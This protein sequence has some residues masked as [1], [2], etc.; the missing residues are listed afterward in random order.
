MPR[1]PALVLTGHDLCTG[2]TP[3]S[4][5]PTNTVISVDDLA[6]ILRTFQAQGYRFVRLADFLQHRRQGGVALLTFDDAY[7]ALDELGL[8]LL[9]RLGVPA[10]VFA[11]TGSL[12]GG[13]DP[14][15]HFIDELRDKWP[16]LSAE[17]RWSIGDHS[18]TRAILAHSGHASL[19]ELLPLE[20]VH[21]AF[22][23]A[24]GPT[25]LAD[26]STFLTGKPGLARRTM[27]VDDV[28][29][30]QASDLIEIGAH[31]VTHRAFI[32]M[33][34]ADVEREIAQ[35]TE[36]IAELSGRPAGSIAFAYPYGFV[37]AHAAA[38]VSRRCAAGFTCY[39]RPLS[40]LDRAAMLPRINLDRRT[41]KIARSR[42]PT[43]SSL[44][45]ETRLYARTPAGQRI[46]R[47]IRA[48]FRA[49]RAG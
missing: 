2:Q 5:S 41:L 36:A 19:G 31:S 32:E 34:D 20:S 47:P 27:T 30:L 13:G 22:A 24:L 45:E 48:L 7:R 8:P 37:T 25:A 12:L 6:A 1:L 40:A 11:V 23:A 38:T 44:Y 10:L 35:S 42:W 21:G 9:Q 4:R 49:V 15:P 33:A 28:R 14:F 17:T 43:L 39:E 18:S 16:M 26:F 29:R 3:R 46:V